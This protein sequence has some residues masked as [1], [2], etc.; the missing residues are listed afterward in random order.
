MTDRPYLVTTV[1]RAGSCEATY[2]LFAC[3]VRYVARMRERY[4]RAHITI[5]NTD[6]M[7]RD[8]ERLIDGLTDEERDEV[9]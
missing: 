3:A 7:D 4:P 2:A 1:D 8:G 9:P 6:R 5:V